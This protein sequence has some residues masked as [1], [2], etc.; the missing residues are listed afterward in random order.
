MGSTMWGG[1][2]EDAPE[3]GPPI[4]SDGVWYIIVNA[5]GSEITASL[6]SDASFDTRISVYCGPCSDLACLAGDDDGCIETGRST[7]TW[8]AQ[9]GSTYR[10]LVHGAF[11]EVGDFTLQV[12]E[13]PPCE[14][15]IE[16]SCLGDLDGDCMVGVK[17]LL[18][19]LGNW[20]LCGDCNDCP[21]D[22]D[23]DCSV[24]V[25]DLLILLGNWG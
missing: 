10:I 5:P 15:A 20:G 22:L 19:L 18:I 25:K 23:G 9:A 2:D 12:D 4:E 21:A 7:V 8:C 6:C 13:G 3:C 24:G 14:D 11:G 16:C 1:V 17:D